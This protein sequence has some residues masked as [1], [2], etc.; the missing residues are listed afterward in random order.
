VAKDASTSILG[1]REFSITFGSDLRDKAMVLESLCLMN[2]MDK[3]E[4]LVKEI[5][6]ELS[7]DKWL[8]TQ[9]TAYALMAMAR[10]AGVAEGGG[11]MEFTFIWNKEKK[12]TVSS[13]YPVVQVSLAADNQRTRSLE[14]VNTGKV[15]VYPRLILEGIPAVG[16]EKA[17]KNN[18]SIEVEYLT[19]DGDALNPSQLEQGTDL[20]A[21]VTIK[22]TGKLGT[23][24]EV[25]LSHLF[26]S[27]WEIHNVRM[28]A[29]EHS[30]GSEF[31]Y[32][33][34]RDDRVYTY[35]DIKQGESKTFKVLLNASYLGKF[36]L[37]LVMAE[38]MYD[39]TINARVP[40]Q[41]ITVVRPRGND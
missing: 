1:Y 41:W 22:N 30:S 4:P 3:A 21:A 6:E 10:Y 18:M 5:S 12:R 16:T 7:S 27:G 39:G 26:P 20:V 19:L 34:I 33:D 25:A 29:S 35:F 11:E 8:S 38:V 32:Q 40:G 37:P 36:Y 14:F 2:Q 23:Y 24:E 13:P 15:T 9:T 28:D 31:D 17:A